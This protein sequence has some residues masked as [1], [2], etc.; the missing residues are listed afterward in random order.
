[1]ENNNIS[2]F[3]YTFRNFISE[4]TQKNG[5][6]DLMYLNSLSEAD[7]FTV[8]DKLI[9]ALYKSSME[10]YNFID[11]G[12]IPKSKGDID[13][14]PQIEQIEE[15]IELIEKIIPGL[16]E[17]KLSK[18]TLLIL[19]SYKKEFSLGFIQEV[20]LIVVIYNTIVMT[21]LFM[22]DVSINVCVDYLRTPNGTVEKSREVYT[23][24]GDQY[25]VAI[26]S[27]VKFIK[28]SEKGDLKKLFDNSLKKENFIGSMG[29]GIGMSVSAT[30]I[31]GVAAVALAI[32]IVPIIRELLYFFYNLRMSTS[33]YFR[34]QAEF[35]EIN[36]TELR[37]NNA[38]S[39]IIKKQE[40]RIRQLEKLADKFDIQCKNANNKTKR[41]LSAKISTDN[42]KTTLVSDNDDISAFSLL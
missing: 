41:E 9:A 37:N 11:F 16:D 24:K 8:S 42:I 4:S 26:D 15:V 7:N 22:I 33:E 20:P 34:K 5:Y 13:R 12:N 2:L 19:R 21:L 6:K 30:A 3:K 36:V 29:I 25:S 17:N 10:K 1:M 28:A 23:T 18:D 39:T 32:A 35:L 31:A 14:L 40:A 38:K 27:L